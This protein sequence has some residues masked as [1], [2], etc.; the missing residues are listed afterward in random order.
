MWIPGDV[1][2]E[3]LGWFSRLQERASFD[4]GGVKK[5]KLDVILPKGHSYTAADGSSVACI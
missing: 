3:S 2:H 1:K 5:D 4:F